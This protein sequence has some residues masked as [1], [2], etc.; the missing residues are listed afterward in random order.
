[1]KHNG[2]NL[3]NGPSKLCQ[4]LAITKNTVNKLDLCKSDMIWL[5]KGDAVK[6]KSMVK[7]KR[8]NIGYADDWIEKP[9]RFYI[10]GNPFISVKD[11]AAEQELTACQLQG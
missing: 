4:A 5:E 10:Q 3:C 2:K 9:L 7:C 1:M 8:I 6:D 11:K